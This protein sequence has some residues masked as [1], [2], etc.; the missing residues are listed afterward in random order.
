VQDWSLVADNVWEFSMN[1][2]I[3]KKVERLVIN[4]SVDD[5][6][7][8]LQVVK[9]SFWEE[10][11]LVTRCRPR[12]PAKKNAPTEFRRRHDVATDQLI[13]DIVTGPARCTRIFER[14]R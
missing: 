1:T 11:E 6:I 13:L 14:Q 3:G 7:D 4:G 9:E 10:H 2:P 5:E 8:G 12:D